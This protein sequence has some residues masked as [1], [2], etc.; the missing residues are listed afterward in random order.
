MRPPLLPFKRCAACREHPDKG[1]DAA[2]FRQTQSAF[3]LLRGLFEDRAISSFATAAADAI[4]AFQTSGAAEAFGGGRHPMWEFYQEAAAEPVPSFRVELAKSGVSRCMATGG[5]VRHAHDIIPKS[6]IRVGRIDM[7]SG[8]YTKWMHLACWRVPSKI[9]LGVLQLDP[10]D[11]DAF[12]QALAQM[13]EVLFCGFQAL[14]QDQ[15][16]HV[17]SHIMDR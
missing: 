9:W 1:G 4:P 13:N 12:E 2:A 15:R 17:V 14:P 8:T 6:A 10:D 5:A 7:Q 16:K 3:E 11:A